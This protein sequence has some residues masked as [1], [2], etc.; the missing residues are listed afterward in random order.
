LFWLD[1]AEPEWGRYTFDN[2]RYY[3]GPVVKVGNIYPQQFARAF[4]DGRHRSGDDQIVN[5]VRAA[6]AGSQRYGALVWSGD[7]NST[8]AD[9][10]NQ[11]T[12]GIHMGIAGIPWFTTDIGG[13]HNGD[14]QD[15]A[16]RELLIRWFQFGAFTPVM[17]LHGDRRPVEHIHAADGTLRLASG[18]DNEIW[19][20]GDDVYHV[21]AGYIEVREK[22]RPYL[23]KAMR[24]AH[25]NGQPVMRAMFHEFPLDQNAWDC[26]DQYLLGPDLLI[27]PI[28]EAGATSRNVCLPAG[29]TWTHI[30]SGKT[31]EGGQVVTV[32]A[33]IEEIPVFSR[34]GELAG[35]VA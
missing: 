26:D 29:A 8:W 31:F 20:F 10:A 9:F 7:I 19:S 33:P 14:I 35:L 6:W 3:A 5:L 2:Y 25:E 34:D 30:W 24:D 1:E 13:F 17:R 28:I 21:L 32:D 22:L 16:F 23:R 18:A 11:I 15:P 12:A 27:A 4:Y